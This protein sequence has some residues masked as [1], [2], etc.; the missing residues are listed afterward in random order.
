MTC[1]FEE[2]PGA[3]KKFKVIHD[4]PT[5]SLVRGGSFT[6]NE[7]A[8]DLLSK[9]EYIKYLFDPSTRVVGL[10]P[11]S[12]DESGAYRIYKPAGG[13]RVRACA[14]AFCH[15][16]DIACG[17]HRSFYPKMQDGVLAFALDDR[18]G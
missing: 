12:P 14:I 5:I 6:I 4:C 1:V 11:A 17:N 13:R 18:D 3:T 16:Y 8:F 2:F 9:P 7:A 10:R 15:H